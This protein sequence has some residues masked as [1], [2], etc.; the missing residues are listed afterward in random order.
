VRFIHFGHRLSTVWQNECFLNQVHNY[1][2][3]LHFPEA[4]WHRWS[5][6]LYVLR[7]M[8]VNM[9]DVGLYIY[10]WTLQLHGLW[11]MLWKFLEVSNALTRISAVFSKKLKYVVYISKWRTALPSF[12]SNSH[13]DVSALSTLS[14]FITVRTGALSV[15]Y[16]YKGTGLLAKLFM[17]SPVWLQWISF[18]I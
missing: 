10:I 18:S 15:Y 6:S 4:E 5:S 9:I 2:V 3:R 8:V 1:K 12:L 16:H 13:S 11:S 14:Q 17:P 7:Y